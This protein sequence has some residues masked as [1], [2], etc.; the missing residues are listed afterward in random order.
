VVQAGVV[1]DSIRYGLRRT[2]WR[3]RNNQGWICQ[4]SSG[5]SEFYPPPIYP[6]YRLKSDPRL[7]L[8]HRSG[9]VRQTSWWVRQIQWGVKPPDPSPPANPTLG[10]IDRLVKVEAKRRL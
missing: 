2:R 4:K 10:K 9:G 3:Q 7:K 6:L 1:S 8:W 5:G